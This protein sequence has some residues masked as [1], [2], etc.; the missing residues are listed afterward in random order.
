MVSKEEEKSALYRRGGLGFPL[1][2]P[3][4]RAL[5]NRCHCYQIFF[6]FN[7]RFSDH[8]LQANGYQDFFSRIEQR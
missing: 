7:L 8:T 1:V 5:R 3:R 4:A 2:G 6:G